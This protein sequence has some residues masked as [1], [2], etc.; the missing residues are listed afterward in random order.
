MRFL[1]RIF[2]NMLT[3]GRLARSLYR[4]LRGVPLQSVVN[5]IPMNG[6]YRQNKRYFARNL[7][8][9]SIVFY[10]LLIQLMPKP[11]QYFATHN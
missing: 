9:L 2:H 6:V 8:L 3:I 1:T 10:Q 5:C 11:Q 4:S 7:G